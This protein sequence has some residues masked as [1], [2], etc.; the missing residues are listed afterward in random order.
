MTTHG[1]NFQGG[2]NNMENINS[3]IDTCLI[4]EYGVPNRHLNSFE[5]DVD[6]L[7]ENEISNFLD[8]LM[9]ADTSIRDLVR[10]SMQTLIEKRL[11]EVTL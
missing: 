9:H 3:Y 6:D 10:S 8:R 1:A 5:L 2:T 4:Q 11:R 7:P